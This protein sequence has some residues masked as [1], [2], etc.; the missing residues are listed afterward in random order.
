MKKLMGWMLVMLSMA[1]YTQDWAQLSR[2]KAA[3]EKLGPPAPGENRIIF[4]G[5]S[6]TEGWLEHYPEFFADKPYINR[7]ISGQTTPQMLARFRQDVID[8]Q[9]KA[10][11]ILAGTNDIAENSGPITLPQIA[12]NIFAMAEMARMYG[13]EVLLCSVLPAADY[14]W[15]PGL[16]P[17]GKIE[18][19]NR[20]L[21]DY[22]E[23]HSLMWV[24]YYSAMNDGKGGLRSDLTYDGV[25]PN[26]KGY[27]VMSEILEQALQK[28]PKKD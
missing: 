10:V 22:A 4:M 8:L 9:P 11:V 26:R 17:A 2:Y 19:L 28:L 24:D 16:Q 13:I 14:P 6:I 27:E 5:N 25:H 1:G 20:M 7:G 15:R 18:Q 23:K 12:G 3:N 21:K